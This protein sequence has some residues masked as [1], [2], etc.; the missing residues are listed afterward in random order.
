MAKWQGYMAK[1]KLADRLE[2]QRGNPAQAGV[3]CEGVDV[4]VREGAAIPHQDHPLQAETGP[5]LGH[6]AWDR[7]GIR[8]IAARGFH[9]DRPAVAIRQHAID[10]ARGALLL[11][12]IVAKPCQGAGGAL[13]IAARHVIQHRAPRDQMA[14]GQFLFDA[15]LARGETR[16]RRSGPEGRRGE[17]GSW[18]PP[19]AREPSLARAT[20]VPGP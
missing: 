1:H 16:A 14:L 19:P 17:A 13:V 18:T 11:V 6:L 10:H 20:A 7:C 9:R 3:L 4:C 12:P 5:Q 2:A 8:G 15:G